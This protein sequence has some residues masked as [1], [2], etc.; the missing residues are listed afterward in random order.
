MGV[1]TREDGAVV[2]MVPAR[3][4]GEAARVVRMAC[5]LNPRQ[6]SRYGWLWEKRKKC[7]EEQEEKE[8][9]HGLQKCQCFIRPPMRR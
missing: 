4:V 8:G 3:M 1:L 7:S 9:N 2:V 5:V 6:A